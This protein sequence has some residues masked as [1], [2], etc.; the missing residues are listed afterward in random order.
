M[1]QA[2]IK[3]VGLLDFNIGDGMIPVPAPFKQPAVTSK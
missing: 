1:S 3:A 2:L